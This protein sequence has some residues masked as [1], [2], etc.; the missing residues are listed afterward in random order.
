MARDGRRVLI[1]DANFRQPTLRQ[2]FPQCKE[3]GLCN[4][5]VGQGKFSAKTEARS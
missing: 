1:V 3:T 5:L 4:A 2:L